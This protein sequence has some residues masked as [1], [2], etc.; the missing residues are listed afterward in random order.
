MCQKHLPAW[1]FEL[2]EG[3]LGWRPAPSSLSPIRENIQGKEISCFLSVQRILPIEE[4]ERR[5][6]SNAGHFAHVKAGGEALQGKRRSP[7]RSAYSKASC[8]TEGSDFADV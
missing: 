5:G 4:R 3:L 7:L 6:G 1:A 8:T 2:T